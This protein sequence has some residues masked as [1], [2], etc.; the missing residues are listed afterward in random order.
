VFAESATLTITAAAVSTKFDD[1]SNN[2]R[3][4][5]GRTN[6]ASTALRSFVITGGVEQAALNAGTTT[7]G[8][9]AKTALAYSANSFIGAANTTLTSEDTSGTVPVVTR[10]G[11]GVDLVDQVYL[12]G[13]IKRIAYYPRRLANTEL[14]SITS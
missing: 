7:S 12:N 13:T 8:V 2:N 6:L 11:I 4:Q 14:T 5:A 1:G 3:V 10:A 9:F